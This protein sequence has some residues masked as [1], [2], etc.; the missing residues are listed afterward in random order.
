MNPLAAV[1]HKE[2]VGAAGLRSVENC[3]AQFA[4]EDS[5]TNFAAHRSRKDGHSERG[6]GKTASDVRRKVSVDMHS[7]HDDWDR[8]EHL[9]LRARMAGL[10]PMRSSHK[11]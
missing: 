8:P 11:R 3:T 9:E 5:I 7:S 10:S 4:A 2:G 1:A 6:S